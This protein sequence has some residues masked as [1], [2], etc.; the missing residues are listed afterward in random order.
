MFQLLTTLQQNRELS[1]EE[2]GEFSALLLDPSASSS[3]KAE[4]LK[5][6]AKKGETVNEITA[7]VHCF[8]E[9]ARRPDF[10]HITKGYP[11]IDVCGTGGDK[12][13][14]FNV[15]TTSMFVIAAGGAKVIKH[16]NRGVTSASG[17]S[18]VLNA[19]GIP[20]Q[21]SDEQLGEALDCA[22]VCFLFAP[23][24]H[25]A[26][27]EVAEVR[28]MLAKGG[29]R[30]IF[31]I[32][33]PLLNPALPEYQMVGVTMQEQTAN[34]AQIL[35]NLGRKQAYTVTGYTEDGSPVDEC[36]TM[37]NNELYISGK[38][39]DI[40]RKSFSPKDYGL[41]SSAIEDLKGGGA[42]E[43]SKTL[44]AILKGDERGAKRDIVLLNAGAGLACCEIA[45][46]IE[47]GMKMA[48]ELI[49]SGHAIH[50]LEEFQAVF[51]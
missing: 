42:E 1:V 49:D 15:S 46:S 30:T 13:N 40:V 36:S 10:S 26:F 23:M 29:V 5:A 35:K 18:D 45:S 12:L 32:I 47:N 21:L 37:G 3:L 4:L 24:F 19:L 6:L 22:N 51:R 20:M 33:G 9:K 41:S 44:K 25:P 38:G 31:N 17:S 48:A 27:K 16:G 8:L 43:N 11:T 50:K 34:F 28:R 7:F 39:Q 14:L 2:I